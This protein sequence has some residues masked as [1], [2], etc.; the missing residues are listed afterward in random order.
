MLPVWVLLLPCL[1][2][3]TF[4]REAPELDIE[5]TL[6]LTPAVEALLL[7]P[8][9]ETTLSWDVLLTI[10]LTLG[11]ATLY[12]A[13]SV[14]RNFCTLATHA[15]KS[16]YGTRHKGKV[17]LSY[18]KI[19]HQ[20][21]LVMGKVEEQSG[22]DK[23]GIGLG[24]SPD[25]QR[26][27]L[28]LEAE[29]GLCTGGPLWKMQPDFIWEDPAFDVLTDERRITVLPYVLDRMERDTYWIHLIR[30]LIELERFDLLAQL[31]FPKI[32]AQYF[33][34]L[35]GTM[36]PKSVVMVAAKSYSKR[37][38]TS[39][40]ASLLAKAGFGDEA[41]AIP[42]DNCPIPLCLLQQF[43]GPSAFTGK[44]HVLTDGLDESSL[45][46]WMGML[47][48]TNERVEELL[49]LVLEHGDDKS[50][51]LAKAF[52]GPVSGGRLTEVESDVYHAMLVRFR[53][54]SLCTE[55]LAQNYTAMIEDLPTFGYHTASALLDCGQ[56]RLLNPVDS[57]AAICATS[58]PFISKMRR[59]GDKALYPLIKG[60][61]EYTT[62][63]PNL[64][65]RLIQRK[66]DEPLVRL[67]WDSIR[68]TADLPTLSYFS[69]SAPV[70][71]LKCLAFNRD[72]S[73]D[74]MEDMFGLPTD[75]QWDGD[76]ISKEIRLLCTAMFWEA[77]EGV[78]EH[79]LAQVPDNFELWC[80]RV[81]SLI[82]V[83]RYSDGFCK[84]LIERLGPLSYNLPDGIVHMRPGLSSV[85]HL[86][87]VNPLQ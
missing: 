39:K 25:Y 26:I 60:H 33:T 46:F 41:A 30:G 8:V 87:V 2:S 61:L 71:A 75:A 57:D 62:M 38:P 66:A 9:I 68:N 76:R 73:V 49:R 78:I 45:S 81:W 69:C 48:E 55:Q 74:S 23:A 21:D 56:L 70:D 35:M 3:A 1:A 82:R 86:L 44:G 77:P 7:A 65:K 18:S 50:T 67:V 43:G 79:F 19:L 32:T 40:L 14:S 31:A 58:G 64:L 22:A 24:S 59:L 63:A 10:F 36:A 15:L 52:F 54:S 5:T 4:L 85:I 37:E 42:D 47:L 17:Y 27:Q 34:Q 20:R 13:A 29:F 84:K 80:G 72:I 11:I 12:Q 6:P 83:K 16:L 51:R 28:I 53:F